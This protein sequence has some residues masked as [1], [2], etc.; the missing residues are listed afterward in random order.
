MG[1]TNRCSPYEGCQSRDGHCLIFYLFS[2]LAVSKLFGLV[3]RAQLPVSCF[4]PRRVTSSY[5]S[6][7][8]VRAHDVVLDFREAALGGTRPI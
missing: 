8:F 3:R 7:A 5:S 6:I 2:F 4:P 1:L